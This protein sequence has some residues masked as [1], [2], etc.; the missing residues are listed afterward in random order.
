[1]QAVYSGATKGDLLRMQAARDAVRY[2]RPAQAAIAFAEIDPLAQ[3]TDE[4][5]DRR[6]AELRGRNALTI[7]AAESV[8]GSWA[9]GASN[10][11]AGQPGRSDTD[12]GSATP[13]TEGS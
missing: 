3:L 8:D 6:L 2:E 1:M 12:A 4:Q 11:Q 13:S 5:I 10:A 7:T 9:D